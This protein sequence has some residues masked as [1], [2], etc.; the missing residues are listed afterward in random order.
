M[1]PGDKVTTY[2]YLVCGECSF[3]RRA[4]ESLCLNYRGLPG[5]QIDG[6]YAEYVLLPAYN[7]VP[8]P[9]GI[10]FLDATII[11]DATTTSY[12]VCNSRAQVRPGDSVMIV[13]AA[14]GVGVHMIQV[15]RFFGG[16]VIAVD[17]DDAKLARTVEYGAAHRVNFRDPAAKEALLAATGGR[18]ADVAVDLIGRPETVEWSLSALGRGGRLVLLTTFPGVTARL[19]PRHFVLEEITVTGSRYASRFEEDAAIDLVRHG[20]VRPVISEVVTLERVDELHDKLRRA[21]FFGR[22]AI[23]PGAQ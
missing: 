20:K 9:D 15:A 11:P 10:P 12:H 8:L 17:I 7:V 6:G 21:E 22:G 14:G 4:R 3:C 19:E 1:R 13:G 2:N 23:L 16:E 5:L 18:G